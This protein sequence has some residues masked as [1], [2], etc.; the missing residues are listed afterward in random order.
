MG[1]KIP[2]KKHLGVKDPL[3]QKRRREMMMKDKINAP[4]KHADFQEIPKTVLEMNRLR[5]L[6]KNSSDK[7]QNAKKKKKNPQQ[8]A[9]VDIRQLSGA[10]P[11][12]PGMNQQD[13][14]LPRLKQRKGESEK[15]FINRVENA[16]S[17]L[18]NEVQMEAQHNVVVKRNKAGDVVSV[19][20]G[21]KKLDDAA[22]QKI[23]KSVQDFH[24]GKK[25]DWKEERKIKKLQTFHRTDK[26]GSLKKRPG[27]KQRQKMKKAPTKLE[28]ELAG[29]ER[30]YETVKFGEVVH[31][32]PNLNRRPR[33]VDPSSKPSVKGL[34]LSRM[35]SQNEPS[36]AEKQRIE[37]RRQSVV[38]AYRELKAALRSK[39]S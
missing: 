22:K 11:T 28:K 35:L 1:R 38:Q 34:L 2:G 16:T 8:R 12:L 6:A 23:R 3:V 19:E 9:L 4:P 14:N 17:D 26:G 36:L 31:G 5:E 7:I 30:R 13:R 33:G 20:K 18:I 25:P 15:T 39:P 24:L 27:K 32:P 37:E 29:V 10:G 21:K